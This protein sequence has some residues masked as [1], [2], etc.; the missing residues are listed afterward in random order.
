[1]KNLSQ[2]ISSFEVKANQDDYAI[3]SKD[4]LEQ[5]AQ[6]LKDYERLKY[7]EERLN[8]D[9]VISLNSSEFANPSRANLGQK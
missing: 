2:L 8:S 1:V 7:A 4:D 5:A 3:V 9:N 6:L